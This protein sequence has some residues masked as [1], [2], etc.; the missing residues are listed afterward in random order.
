MFA[1]HGVL[2]SA[3]GC[4]YHCLSIT[5]NESQPKS[6]C[7]DE[8]NVANMARIPNTVKETKRDYILNTSKL[9]NRYILYSVITHLIIIINYSLIGLSMCSSN[10]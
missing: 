6:I 8:N 5:R 2:C 9:L 4:E 3:S 10:L 7:M 1:N